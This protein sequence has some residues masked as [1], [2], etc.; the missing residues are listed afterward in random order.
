MPGKLNK[1]V[2][3][4]F[5]ARRKINALGLTLITAASAVI[6]LICALTNFAHTDVIAIV[7]VA[8]VL[9]CLVQSV[10]MRKAFR[11]IRKFKGWRKK[12]K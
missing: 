5:I 11:T 8:L 10:K 9:L 6:T 4:S 12:N 2:I 7:T 3:K 1:Q